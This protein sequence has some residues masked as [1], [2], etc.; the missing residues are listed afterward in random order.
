MQIL[1]QSTSGWGVSRYWS[2]GRTDN[3][4]LGSS[5]IQQLC[6]ADTVTRNPQRALTNFGMVLTARRL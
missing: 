6:A 4:R 2:D 3:L 1:L 5:Q